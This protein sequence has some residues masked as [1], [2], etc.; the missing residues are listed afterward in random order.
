MRSLSKVLKLRIILENKF[1]KR[2]DSIMVSIRFTSF[3]KVKNLLGKNAKII[4]TA[5]IIKRVYYIYRD[6]TKLF[7]LQKKKVKKKR[8][9]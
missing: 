2:G 9:R 7:R 6:Y 5:G 8:K 1:C 3:W 4:T